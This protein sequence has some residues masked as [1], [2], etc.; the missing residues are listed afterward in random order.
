MGARKSDDAAPLAAP[1]TTARAGCEDVQSAA[2][3]R[4][5][6]PASVVEGQPRSQPALRKKVSWQLEAGEQAGLAGARPSGAAD[7]LREACT[8]A[9][10]CEQAQPLQDGE[11]ECNP[12]EGE[13]LE[14]MSGAP[15][16][17]A[18]NAG[19]LPEEGASAKSR[20]ETA[21]G[22]QAVCGG[23]SADDSG[24]PVVDP[25]RS[26]AVEAGPASGAASAGAAHASAAN[27]SP[28]PVEDPERE[29]Q[30]ERLLQRL[31]EE[32]DAARAGAAAARDAEDAAE[33]AAAT[34]T[35]QR[36][37]L[38]AALAGAAAAHAA[39]LSPQL[40]ALREARPRPA[41]QCTARQSA[42]Q[43]LQAGLEIER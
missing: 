20:D 18:S 42:L 15:E 34:L 12:S 36:R 28:D 43:A 32:A 1:G 39:A 27:D 17:P 37:E 7:R 25:G 13:L 2:G 19:R 41:Y 24:S 6:Q 23:V 16:L 38:R 29:A 21:Q 9:A 35:A 14:S 4:A 10:L 5:A 8:P 31:E 26:A 11:G 22:E 30:R 40:A 33:E 3:A